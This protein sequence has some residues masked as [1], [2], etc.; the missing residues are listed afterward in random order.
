MKKIKKESGQSLVELAISITVIVMLLAGAAEFGIALFQYIQLTDAAQEGALYGSI[1][2]A[3]TAEIMNRIREVSDTPI[4]LSDYT[5][6]P[7]SNITIA[8]LDK[9]GTPITG[10]TTPA[11]CSGGQITVEVRYY[12]VFFI[13]F[14]KLFAGGA[15][16]IPLTGTVIDTIL[17]CP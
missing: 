2:P 16:Q 7:N 12:H 11:N 4:D 9:N 10:A 8:A 15:T 6:M 1:D 5:V 13:P 17:T 3:N 14:A